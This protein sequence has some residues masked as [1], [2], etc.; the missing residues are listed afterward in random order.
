MAAAA[1]RSSSIGPELEKAATSIK[2]AEALIITAGAGIG[3]D[4]GLP[5][6]R[7]PEGFWKAY[8]PLKDKGIKLAEMANPKWF[9]EDPE[10]AW[11]FYGHRINLYAETEP[12]KGF[13]I[14]KRWA[15]AKEKGH[16]VYTSNVDGHF[17]R[18]GFSEDNV[19]EC[20]GSLY[21]LQCVDPKTQSNDIWPTPKDQIKGIDVSTLRMAPPLPHGPP[22]AK[23]PVLARPNVVMFG[24]WEFVGTRTSTQ[25][26]RYQNFIK[27]LKEVNFA[28]IEIGAGTSIPTIRHQS[29]SIIEDFKGATLIRIN[30]QEP[31]VPDWHRSISLPMKG[32]EAL[33]VIDKLMVKC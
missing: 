11:G 28:V 7:G 27:T 26:L 5:D 33:E 8:P 22:G 6:Y 14:L 18:A 16:F 4:S 10:F 23:K 9:E 3:V 32:L 19:V 15:L 1:P 25:E 13:Q 29:Q 2:N 20:H 31:E 24:D 17:Q 21:F 30:P 12:H